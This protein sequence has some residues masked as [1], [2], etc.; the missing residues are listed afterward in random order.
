MDRVDTVINWFLLVFGACVVWMGMQA[1]AE[2]STVDMKRVIYDI[3]TNNGRYYA[4]K[5]NT[6]KQ[7]I[8]S[9][10]RTGT[11]ASAEREKLALEFE[12]RLQAQD[13]SY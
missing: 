11:I 1:I 13:R 6:D 4:S 7:S 10:N 5:D 8:P 9:G 3:Q 12:A 2:L